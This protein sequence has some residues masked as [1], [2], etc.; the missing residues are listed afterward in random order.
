MVK[1][2]NETQQTKVLS[3]THLYSLEYIPENRPLLPLVRLGSVLVTVCGQRVQFVAQFLPVMEL[4]LL[5]EDRH[6]C[7]ILDQ[8]KLTDSIRTLY[9]ETS[10][11]MQPDSQ[12]KMPLN[13]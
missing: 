10:H 8:Q 6:K 2:V 9:K 13:V 5:E 7:Y 1:L 11:L 12:V 3:H 4:K